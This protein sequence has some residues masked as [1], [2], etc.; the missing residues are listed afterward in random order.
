M[1]GQRKGD[2]A[3]RILASFSYLKLLTYSHCGGFILPHYHL[4]VTTLNTS[5]SPNYQHNALS[6]KGW[7]NERIS[8]SVL[9]LWFGRY[10]LCNSR[11]SKYDWQFLCWGLINF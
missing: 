7:I 10:A 4:T 5:T 2:K 3:V 8:T 6:T 9:V 1:I 11:C